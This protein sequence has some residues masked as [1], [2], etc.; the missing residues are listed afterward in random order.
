MDTAASGL[1]EMSVTVPP[2]EPFGAFR[3]FGAFGLPERLDC[4][5]LVER[6][7]GRLMWRS[8]KGQE[9]DRQ[10]LST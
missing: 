5:S 4:R 9:T 3:A 8:R 6:K 1:F 10:F 2:I 7:P